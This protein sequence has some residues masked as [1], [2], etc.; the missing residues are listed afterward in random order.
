MI[1][2]ISNLVGL[3]ETEANARL[4]EEGFNELPQA[5]RR[6]PLRIIL[7]VLRE[8]MLALL[9][10]GG[11]IYVALGDLK[12]A[13]ILIVFASMSVVITVVQE[14]RTER[15]LEALRDLTSPRALVMILD[16]PSPPVAQCSSSLSCSSPYGARDFVFKVYVTYREGWGLTY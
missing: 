4:E 11:L 15:V 9:L 16:W 12:E 13:L 2:T 6:T 5:D 7:D 14:S 10:G 1:G 3:T 8:P